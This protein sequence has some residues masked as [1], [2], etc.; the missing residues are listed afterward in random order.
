MNTGSALNIDSSN[1]LSGD[2]CNYLMN[3][4][5]CLLTLDG[6]YKAKPSTESITGLNLAA[7]RPTTVQV[8]S[9][10]HSIG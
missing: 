3:D 6:P 1:F 10:R 8:T 2:V 5:T 7:V 9:C 4:V